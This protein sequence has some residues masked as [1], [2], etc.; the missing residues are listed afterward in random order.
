[1]ILSIRSN[2]CMDLSLDT[3][4]GRVRGI[5]EGIQYLDVG[6]LHLLDV[7]YGVGEQSEINRINTYYFAGLWRPWS[8]VPM[9]TSGDLRIPVDSDE[10]ERKIKEYLEA[11]IDPDMDDMDDAFNLFMGPKR[12]SSVKARMS[13]IHDLQAQEYQT[14]SVRTPTHRLCL[15]GSFQRYEPRDWTKT[16]EQLKG[17]TVYLA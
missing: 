12:F 1:M 5:P 17:S 10:R 9:L 7:E 6:Y 14:K 16:A 13:F 4:T 8:D 15:G 3:D 2:G 11:V